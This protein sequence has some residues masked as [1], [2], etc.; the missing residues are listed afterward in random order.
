MVGQRQVA[1]YHR[2]TTHRA[3]GTNDSAASH[4]CTAGHGGV[5]SD[6]HVVSNL[7]QVVELDTIFKH[8]VIECTPVNT[9]VGT[10]FYVIANA[11]SPQLLNLDPCTL[12]RRKAESI[13]SNDNA[14]VEYA[15]L[16]NRATCG[17]GHTRM[18]EAITPNAAVW[19]DHGM[20]PYS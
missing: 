18:Q 20:R 9:A 6:M 8:S 13:G 4:A 14:A 1:Q 16:A 12:V 5:C 7:N 2:A 19:A 3:V 11:D 15:A 10:N 17:N